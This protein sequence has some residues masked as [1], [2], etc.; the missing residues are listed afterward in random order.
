MEAI[1]DL[2]DRKSLREC[3]AKRL[4]RRLRDADTF[5]AVM[6]GIGRRTDL[7]RLCRGLVDEVVVWTYPHESQRLEGLVKNLRINRLTKSN[8]KDIVVPSGIEALTDD[9]LE[10]LLE[11]SP[12]QTG[13]GPAA[14]DIDEGHE[15]M[16]LA[17]ER[18]RVL[19]TDG[20][21]LEPPKY[22]RFFVWR[23]NDVNRIAALELKQ[24][25][26]LIELPAIASTSRDLVH[27]VFSL[28]PGFSEVQ[29]NA[30]RWREILGYKY[31]HWA[32]QKEEAGET[33][34]MAAFFRDV[35]PTVDVDVQA[36]R[37][38]LNEHVEMPHTDNLEALLRDLG[39]PTALARRIAA[40]QSDYRSLRLRAHKAMASELAAMVKRRMG[41]G[42]SLDDDAE[43][44]EVLNEVQELLKGHLAQVRLSQIEKVERNG[45]TDAASQ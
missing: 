43:D 45:T 17:I 32:I 4:P 40:A 42:V 5:T 18:V 44:D 31:R 13:G 2:G 19:L 30:L 35:L 34:S 3:R 1:V 23:R 26:L 36:V 12:S 29:S 38:W 33:P 20:R 6:L 41:H 37:N 10:D 11:W 7:E 39:T 25:D 27:A 16:G 24:G 9:A 8:E 21:V 22:R 14:D 15:A 28:S